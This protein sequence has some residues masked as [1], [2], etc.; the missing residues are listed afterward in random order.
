MEIFLARVAEMLRGNRRKGT[1]VCWWLCLATKLNPFRTTHVTWKGEQISGGFTHLCQGLC[2]LLWIVPGRYIASHWTTLICTSM[3]WLSLSSWLTVIL[4]H[5][6]Q[7]NDCVNGS[8]E[9]TFYKN[10]MMLQM[11]AEW[12]EDVFSLVNKTNSIIGAFYLFVQEL[13]HP[14]LIST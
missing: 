6:M 13:F 7:H 12:V 1:A 10:Q 2:G 4:L 5:S 8:I 9:Y 3:Q 11:E 14:R